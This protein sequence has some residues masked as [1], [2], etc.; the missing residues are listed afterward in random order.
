MVEQMKKPHEPLPDWVRKK[1]R[2][3][4]TVEALIREAAAPPIG[5]QRMTAV[6]LI[7]Q[8]CLS[9]CKEA[10][11]N[12]YVVISDSASPIQVIDWRSMSFR[13]QQKNVKEAK[14]SEYYMNELHTV[15]QPLFSELF[16]GHCVENISVKQLRSV[17]EQT[18]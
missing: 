6:K 5:K 8:S 1:K 11:F 2:N 10:V 17:A 7:V 14:G 18:G 9:S 13:L 15:V 12:R 16:V 4:R 3:T